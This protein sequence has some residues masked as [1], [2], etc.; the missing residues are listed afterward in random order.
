MKKFVWPLLIIFFLLGG[1]A[2]ILIGQVVFP[3]EVRPETVEAISANWSQSGHSDAQSI[4]FTYW[5]QRDP[6]VISPTCAK[7]HSAYGYLDF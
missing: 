5:D 4:S 2:A 3:L 1:L 7:C 6:P